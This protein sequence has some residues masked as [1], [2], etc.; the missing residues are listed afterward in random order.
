[1]WCVSIIPQNTDHSE[2]AAGNN[3]TICETNEKIKVL[4]DSYGCEYVDLYPSLTDENGLLDG[5]Y[6]SDGLH[7]NRKGYAVW[8]GVMKELLK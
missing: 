7:L 3:A 6:S 1:M 8:T 2:H 5:K 4:A